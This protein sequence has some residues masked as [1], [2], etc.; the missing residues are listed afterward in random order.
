MK[1][2]HKLALIILAA[3]VMTGT[4]LYAHKASV[5]TAQTVCNNKNGKIVCTTSGGK[6]DSPQ[7]VTTDCIE[8]NGKVKCR[9]I[10]R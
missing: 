4:I 6:V 10:V 5:G 7:Q 9:S 3:G 2:S 1:N 8:E